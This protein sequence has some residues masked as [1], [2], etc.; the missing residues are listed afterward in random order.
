MYS[1]GDKVVYPRHGAGRVVRIEQKE[2]LGQTREYLTIEILHDR[3]T[4]MI[5]VESAERAGLRKV[6][7]ADAVAEVFA[8]LR[9]EPV[10]MPGTWHTRFKLNQE[11]LGTGDVLEVATVVR[12]LAAKQ[13][14][15]DLPQGERRMFM[16]ARKILASE[17]MYALDRSEEEAMAL[18]DEVLDESSLA[19]PAPIE[20]LLEPRAVS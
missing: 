11:K 12:Y 6:I 15:R 7:A 16:N 2:V 18:L 3:M 5:P 19:A 8:V 10:C 1:V 20:Q 4:A 17:L 13:A 14:E 9:G